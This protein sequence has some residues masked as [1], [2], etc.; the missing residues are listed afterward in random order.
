MSV[1]SEQ[2]DDPDEVKL[3]A[4]MQQY[5]DI[6]RIDMVDT[7]ADLSMKTLR[8]FSVLPQ[9][10]D[11][12]FYFKIDDDVA[13]NVDALAD[14]LDAR[15]TQGNLYLVGSCFQTFASMHH[16]LHCCTLFLPACA[17]FYIICSACSA[18]NAICCDILQFED[19][20]AVH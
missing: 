9:K 16:V 1:C 6:V 14:Y 7:Y 17:S 8:M 5:G 20:C 11:A 2:K 18:L 19:K 15:R 10:I 3:K 13:V 4:E 12:D